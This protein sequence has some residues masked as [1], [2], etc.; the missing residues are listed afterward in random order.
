MASNLDTNSFFR[1][2]DK[3]WSIKSHTLD[4]LRTELKKWTRKN[5]DD[6]R[7]ALDNPGLLN[8]LVHICLKSS[9]YQGT[10]C[11]F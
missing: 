11:T 4:T 10:P 8:D 7:A 1:K 5:S 3:E 2:K 9:S 6:I